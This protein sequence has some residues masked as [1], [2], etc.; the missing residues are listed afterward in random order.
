[1]DKIIIGRDPEVCDIVVDDPANV[2]SRQHALLGVISRKKFTIVDCST[3]GTYVNGIK[4][5]YGVERSV[6][7]DDI[8]SFAHVVNLDWSLVTGPMKKKRNKNLLLSLVIFLFVVIL[9]GGGL[10]LLDSKGIIDLHSNRGEVI[11]GPDMNDS[12]VGD[13][14]TK[15]ITKEPVDS[16]NKVK[17]V[18]TPKPKTD[19]KE[20][21]KPEKANSTSKSTGKSNNKE[22]KKEDSKAPEEAKQDPDTPSQEPQEEEVLVNSIL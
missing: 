10:W 14:I 18:D 20:Q 7:P 4:L 3:N 12:Q 16:V 1:M 5:E 22:I 6:T 21:P 15:N 17:N 9:G 13:T 2:I 8:I 19:I 11:S